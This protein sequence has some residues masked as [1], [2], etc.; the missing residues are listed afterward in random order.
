[1]SWQLLDS[2]DT[3]QVFGPNLVSESLICTIQSFPSGSVLVRV[4]P[5]SAF[6]AGNGGPLCGSLSAAVE[7]ILEAGV[8]IAATGNMRVDDN[9]LLVDY[10]DFTVAYVPPVATPGEITTVVPIPVQIITADT[11]ILGGSAGVASAP[12]LLNEAYQRLAAMAHG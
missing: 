8:A 4:V 1:M 2:T 3:V 12:E 7:Q 10:V 9:E 6:V 5:Q 11:S